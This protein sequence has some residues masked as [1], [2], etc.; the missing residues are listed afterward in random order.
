MK[1]VIKFLTL[2][3]FMLVL[4]GCG[5]GNLNQGDVYTTIYPI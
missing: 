4:S 2:S 3:L 1:K 5:E